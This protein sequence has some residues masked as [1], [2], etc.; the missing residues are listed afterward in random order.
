[1]FAVDA[2][3]HFRLDKLL[4]QSS[5]WLNQ[6]WLTI[7]VKTAPGGSGGKALYNELQSLPF[8]LTKFTQDLVHTKHESTHQ[9][10]RPVAATDASYRVLLVLSRRSH[11]SVVMRLPS[12]CAD[13]TRK[14]GIQ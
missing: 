13:R 11:G 3:A 1:V 12:G 6:R 8:T 9:H 5:G 7:T 10:G 2:D 4:C 14:D